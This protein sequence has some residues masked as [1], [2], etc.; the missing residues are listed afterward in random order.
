MAA[1]VLVIDNFDS[2]VYN[3]AQAFGRLGA[4]PAVVRN[5]APLA[6][7][8][9]DPPDA[10]V[11]SPGPGGPEDAGVSVDAIVALGPRLPVLGVCLGHQCIAHAYGARVSR[12]HAGPVHGKTSPVSHDGR[13]VFRALPSPFDATRY[14]SLA[15]EELTAAPDL[16]VTARS[17][18]GTIM[19]LR[20]RKLRVEGV[21]FHPES[22]LTGEG[23]RLLG[24]FL[25]AVDPSSRRL[26]SA[27]T[28]SRRRPR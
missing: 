28:A 21:Q 8:V 27:R 20:H 24:N 18:D 23:D 6:R 14:H 9:E 2:F 1:R 26:P 22:V 13:G 3:L 25:A 10:L 7:L 5:D 19:G 12:A 17:P 15:V 11:I 16:E 4:E